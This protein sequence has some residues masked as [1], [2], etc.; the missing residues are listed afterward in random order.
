MNSAILRLPRRAESREREQLVATFVDV[1]TLSIL[2]QTTDHQVVFGRR[3]TGK[4]HLFHHLA[5][6]QEEAG[7]VV[8]VIDLRH[9][10]SNAGLYAD[11]RYPLSE[12]AT[13][14][15]VDTLAEVHNAL[16]DYFVE[17]AGA[18]NQVEA[19]RRLEEFAQ[20]ITEVRVS[21]PVRREREAAITTERGSGVSASVG[22]GP[23]GPS[24]DLSHRRSDDAVHEGSVRESRAGDEECYVHFGATGAAMRAILSVLEGQRLWVLL[25]EWSNVPL[26]LQPLL[27][28]LIR[29]TMLATPRV[30]VKIAAIEHRSSFMVM[31]PN[32]EYTGVE[33]GADMSADVT[34]DDFMV[35][36]NDPERAKQFFQTLISKHI[37]A[38]AREHQ[39]EGIGDDPE[40][41][42]RT[43]FTDRRAI[44]E[45]VRACEGVPRDGMNILGIAAQKANDKAIGVNDIRS[46]A[47]DWYGRDKQS[48]IRGSE[49]LE[50]LLHYIVD[51]VIGERRA[52][53]FLVKSGRRS[54]SIDALYDSRVL[55]VLKRGVSTHDQ[56]GERYDAYKL[57][58]GC[59]VNLVSTQRGPLGLFPPEEGST[60]YADV[61]PDDYRSIRRAILELE[62]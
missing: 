7:D 14:L 56:P 44:D 45:F 58:Y 61:P 27:A 59:Y 18:H 43:A 21:G 39:I 35:F 11:A 4:T 19:Y 28:D 47:K 57:D 55:H 24:I 23:T 34:L 26:D 2:I 60:V 42:F 6:A 54:A 16:L 40:E 38:V 8:C 48:G 15:L 25:D 51:K 5:N 41:V 12:R 52:R 9:V 50:P 33:L 37:G 31:K 13:R 20:A 3:G 22:V 10:G 17:H 30:T 36:E 62:D 1:G 46:A 32:R 49:R 53:A 29:R